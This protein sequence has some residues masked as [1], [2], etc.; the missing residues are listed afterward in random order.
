MQNLR[1]RSTYNA[2]IIHLVH[3]AT[4]LHQWAERLSEYFDIDEKEVG[5][6]GKGKNV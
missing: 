1:R 5:M 2:Y 3:K 6:L 4:H